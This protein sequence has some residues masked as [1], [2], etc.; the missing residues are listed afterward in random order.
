MAEREIKN[1][2]KNSKW[3][4]SGQPANEILLLSCLMRIADSHEIMAQNYVKLQNDVEFW[5][6]RYQNERDER[7]ALENS[8]RAYKGN[9]TRLKNKLEKNYDGK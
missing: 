3:T 8:I 4:V 2:T 9:Y 7:I 1:L 5:K 6:Q